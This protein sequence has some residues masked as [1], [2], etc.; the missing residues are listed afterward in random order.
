MN[1]DEYYLDILP[2]CKIDI[3]PDV[4]KI[5]ARLFPVISSSKSFSVIEEPL[6]EHI[7]EE[8]D[9]KEEDPEDDSK[10]ELEEESDEDEDEDVAEEVNE[11]EEERKIQEM[12]KFMEKL[13][14][15]V[16]GSW[17]MSLEDIENLEKQ[18]VKKRKFS[19]TF[20]QYSDETIV[21]D[22]EE[23]IFLLVVVKCEE[24]VR[25][26]P[27]ILEFVNIA[28][29]EDED[30]IDYECNVSLDLGRILGVGF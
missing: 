28:D 13:E 17:A 11:E 23:Q 25:Y 4:L 20:Y 26:V 12:T 8:D 21:P 9:S 6:Y 15:E 1:Y 27:V 2:C 19:L 7:V 29:E 16:S 18:E 30:D 10:E 3:N 24:N 14:I 22:D 5:D